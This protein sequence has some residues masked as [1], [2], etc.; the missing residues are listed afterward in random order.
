MTVRDVIFPENLDRLKNVSP[1]NLA[2]SK[3]V[4]SPAPHGQNKLF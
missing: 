2:S 1:E 4:F 3:D